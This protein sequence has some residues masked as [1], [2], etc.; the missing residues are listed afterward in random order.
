MRHTYEHTKTGGKTLNAEKVLLNRIRSGDHEAFSLL[1][2]DF[3]LPAFRTAYVILRSKEYAE[4]AVQNALEDC[5][6]SIMKN[7]EIRNFRAWFYRV[8]Y[9]RAID[10]YRVNARKEEVNIDEHHE[11]VVDLQQTTILQLIQNEDKSEMLDLINR[12]PM[13]QGI[14]LLLHYYEELSVKEVSLILNEN[15]NTIKTRLARGRKKLGV[16]FIESRNCEM[17]G[18]LHV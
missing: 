12:L 7:K 9:N 5:Y 14:P 11:I 1:V 4:D 6:I 10:I 17:K 15:I 18:E 13:E 2:E 16:L 3:L 8:V